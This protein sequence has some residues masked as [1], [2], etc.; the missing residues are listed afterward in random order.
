MRE[1]TNL[2]WT[3]TPFAGARRPFPDR[4]P[5][6]AAF[7]IHAAGHSPVAAAAV[8]LP[9]PRTHLLAVSDASVRFGF[10]ALATEEP[11]ETSAVTASI[12]ALLVQA[13]RQAAILAGHRLG[14]QLAALTAAGAGQ[15]TRGI[16]AV[17][18][19]WHSQPSERGLARLHDT[20]SQPGPVTLA[21]VC[22]GYDLHALPA[23]LPPP[24]AD[25]CWVASQILRQ[26]VLYALAIAL[27]AARNVDSYQWDALHLDAVVEAAAWDQL[28]GLS[29]RLP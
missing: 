21:D 27:I 28:T 11:A 17:R 15:P 23:D 5:L 4:T 13:R 16:T 20:G 18:A 19:A 3:D 24:G 25:G 29:P 9:L 26:R 8:Y 7:S 2:A 12:D 22:A 14:D 10:H 6:L 1:A